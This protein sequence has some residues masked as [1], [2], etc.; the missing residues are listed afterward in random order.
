MSVLVIKDFIES[1]VRN[2]IKITIP[3]YATNNTQNKY[4]AD[5]VFAEHIS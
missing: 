3:I 1:H 2:Q 4:V 5:N